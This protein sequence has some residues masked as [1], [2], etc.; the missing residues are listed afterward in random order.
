[1]RN[2]VVSMKVFFTDRMVAESSS[3]SPS[4]HKPRAV[5]RSW[6][7]LAI[8]FELVEPEAVTIDQF[9]LAHDRLF[10]EEVLSGKRENGFG[11]RSSA[12]PAS[13]A[14]TSGSLLAAARSAIQDGGV[15]VA[16]CSGFHHAGYKSVGGFCTF[17]GLMV[18]ACVLRDEERARQVGILDFDQHWGDGTEEMVAALSAPWIRHYSAGALWNSPSQATRFLQT[19]PSVVEMMS[20]CDVILYQA[21]ADPHIDDPLG[22]WLTLTQLRERDRIVF[23]QARHYGVPIAWNLAG[24]YQNPLRKVLDIHDNTLV[25]CAAVFE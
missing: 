1:V 19:I 22:G 17:N 14:Y 5:V 8:P 9:A 18:T 6:Q 2:R 3:F 20:D 7:A 23:E 13:L 4:A 25:E 16:P 21:G 10:V 24:G 12:I 15:A 11:N